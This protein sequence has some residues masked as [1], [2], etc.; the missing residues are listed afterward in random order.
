[1]G[2]DASTCRTQPKRPPSGVGSGAG[3]SVGVGAGVG[4]REAQAVVQAFA[5]KVR[6]LVIYTGK[7]I[8]SQLLPPKDS[9]TPSRM[10][11]TIEELP[12]WHGRKASLNGFEMHR[13]LHR[14]VLLEL[15]FSD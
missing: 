11:S 2:R 1:M 3:S 14:V 5:N 8:A 12:T 10:Q 4:S 6:I 9:Q 7:G 13:T 15:K